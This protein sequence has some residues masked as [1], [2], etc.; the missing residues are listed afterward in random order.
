MIYSNLYY[1]NHI[2]IIY[3]IKIY[4]LRMGIRNVCILLNNFFEISWWNIFI[5]LLQW[6]WSNMIISIYSEKDK[7]FVLESEKFLDWRILTGNED[8]VKIINWF[9]L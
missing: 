8:I 1:I 3:R 6:S 2:N 9:S 5:I 4:K 7:N